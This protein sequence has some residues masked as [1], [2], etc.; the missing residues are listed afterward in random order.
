MQSKYG[1]YLSNSSLLF[2]HN[3]PQNR[4]HSA[5]RF[6]GSVPLN[7]PPLLQPALNRIPDPRGLVGIALFE[8]IPALR[9]L[10][11]V[12]PRFLGDVAD[13]RRDGRDLVSN[14]GLQRR[15]AYSMAWPRPGKRSQQSPELW[16][17][18]RRWIFFSPHS[19]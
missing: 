2:R 16:S 19:E 17:S 3:F 10:L 15:V 5:R 14:L 18:L 11:L 4:R 7:D 6:R 12:F 8:P 13:V 1:G 9:S